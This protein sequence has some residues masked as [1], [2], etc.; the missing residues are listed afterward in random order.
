MIFYPQLRCQIQN[1][2]SVSEGKR[3][4]AKGKRQDFLIDIPPIPYSLF[5]IPY[6]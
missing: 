2:L 3:Q 1:L 5:P 6:E 4:E